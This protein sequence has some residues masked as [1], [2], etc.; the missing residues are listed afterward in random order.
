ML[1][2][3]RPYSRCQPV[4]HRHRE[5]GTSPRDF[6]CGGMCSCLEARSEGECK[7]VKTMM[8][9][10]GQWEWQSLGDVS[11][12]GSIHCCSCV[13]FTGTGQPP[14]LR[15]AIGSAKLTAQF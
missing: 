10:W 4:Q 14:S 9:K 1:C 11:R 15:E 8:G 5:F 6:S 7:I 2:K 3:G 13:L 12:R